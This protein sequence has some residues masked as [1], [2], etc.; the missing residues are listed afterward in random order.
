MKM[1]IASH[2]LE[3]PCNFFKNDDP[4]LFF[5]PM[6]GRVAKRSTFYSLP[7]ALFMELLSAEGR[8]SEEI[9]PFQGDEVLDPDGV[10]PPSAWTIMLAAYGWPRHYLSHRMHRWAYVMWDAARIEHPSVRALIENGRRPFH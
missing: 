8:Y 5:L 4:L 10:Y 3:M 1:N 7:D 6:G 2:D 9:L